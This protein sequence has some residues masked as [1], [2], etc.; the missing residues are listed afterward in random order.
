VRP[1]YLDTHFDGVPI[2]VELLREVAARGVVGCR[3]D[4]L[5]TTDPE[6]VRAMFA[7]CDAAGLRVLAIVRDGDQI[8]QLNAIG[9]W[10]TQAAELWNEPDIDTNR[11]IEPGEYSEMLTEAAY[12]SRAAGIPLYAGAISNLS[13]GGLGWLRKIKPALD[14]YPEVR[15]SVHRYP[16]GGAY[17]SWDR[18]HDGFATRADEVAAL[19]VIIGNRP[20]CV[21]ETGV[22]TAPRITKPYG[23][24]FASRYA[25]ARVEARWTESEQLQQTRQDL[26]F[27]AT[28]D[29]EFVTLYQINCGPTADS[30]E[31][32]GWRRAD[33]TWRPVADVLRA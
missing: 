19:K 2:G 4:L 12:A 33:G 18:P 7:E 31:Q 10:T 16:D 21:S 26:A 15:V 3:V 1:L 8:D 9:L 30:P 13:Q 22:H 11:H 25:W 14:E 29:V 17:E 23:A 20:W 24:W 5:K 28:T 27:W 6:A 32:F